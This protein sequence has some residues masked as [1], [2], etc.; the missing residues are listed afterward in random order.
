MYMCL[1]WDEKMLEQYVAQVRCSVSCRSDDGFPADTATATCTFGL[2]VV[3]DSELG[4]DQ[5]GDIVDGATTYE[6]QT[7]AVNQDTYAWVHLEL[8]IIIFDLFGKLQLVLVA[9]ASSWFDSH[10]QCQ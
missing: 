10:S 7:D 3:L 5:F 4:S 1:S 6:C 8:E 2:R 9:V